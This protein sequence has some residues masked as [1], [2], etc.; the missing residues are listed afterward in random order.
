[1]R[2]SNQIEDMA[3]SKDIHSVIIQEANLSHVSSLATINARA[4]HPTNAYHRRIF[5]KTPLVLSWWE[6]VFTNEINDPA[7][8]AII[9][10]DTTAQ[11][12]NLQVIGTVCMRLMEPDIYSAGLYSMHE[13]TSD[14]D[15]EAFQPSIDFMAD[16]RRK[17]FAGT[18]Q[19]C[20]MLEVV[21][22]DHEWQRRGV[23]TKLVKRAIEIANE[24]GCPVFLEANGFAVEFYLRLGFEEKARAR[25]SGHQE[26]YVQHVLVRPVKTLME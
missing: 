11:D 15:L 14:Q 6:K 25:V 2:G 17:L 22:V 10:V 8:H 23:G 5:P 7:A 20:Y 13:W 19:W 24:K 21:G 9:A 26:E 4:F 1:M 12:K 16:W 3:S 18:G